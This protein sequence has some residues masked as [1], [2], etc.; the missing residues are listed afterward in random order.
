M[1]QKQATSLYSQI[2]N[3]LIPKDYDFFKTLCYTSLERE[4]LSSILSSNENLLT[5]GSQFSHSMVQIFASGVRVLE[6]LIRN[7][8]TSG[9]GLHKLRSLAENNVDNAGIIHNTTSRDPSTSNA[10]MQTYQSSDLE[11]ANDLTELASESGRRSSS[12]SVNLHSMLR[13]SS[14]DAISENRAHEY[15]GG[16]AL[17][18]ALE[19]MRIWFMSI[20]KMNERSL[21]KKNTFGEHSNNDL[22]P[23]LFEVS[24]QS[25][26]LNEKYFFDFLAALKLFLKTSLVSI[27]DSK[28]NFTSNLKA[29]KAIIFLLVD[30]LSSLFSSFLFQEIDAVPVATKA[31]LFLFFLVDFSDIFDSLLRVTSPTFDQNA[32]VYKSPKVNLSFDTLMKVYRIIGILS[33]TSSKILPIVPSTLSSDITSISE[34]LNAYDQYFSRI[35][36]IDRYTFDLEISLK[37]LPI[38]AIDFKYCYLFKPDLLEHRI[39]SASFANW[40]T[41][42]LFNGSNYMRYQTINRIVDFHKNYKAFTYSKDTDDPY[43][44]ELEK[45]QLSRMTSVAQRL[46]DDNIETSDMLPIAFILFTYSRSLS[47]LQALISEQLLNLLKL[48]NSTP[49]KLL[50][51]WLSTLSYIFQYQYRTVNLQ[52]V[53]KLLLAILVKLT[54]NKSITKDS[55]YVPIKALKKCQIDENIWKLSHQ[56]SPI[57]PLSPSG[58]RK[59]HLFYILDTLQNLIRFNLTKRLEIDNY[60]LCFSIIFQILKE[61]L[62]DKEFD[63][64]NYAWSEFSKSVVMVLVFVKKQNILNSKYLKATNNYA[65]LM[66]LIEEILI[67]INILLMKRFCSVESKEEGST[68]QKSIIYDLIYNILLNYDL[69]DN[70]LIE[71]DLEDLPNL[72]RLNECITY[73]DSQF[74]FES[75][76]AHGTKSKRDLQDVE[77]DSPV[78]INTISNFTAEPNNQLFNELKHKYKFKN[79]FRYLDMN[80]DEAFFDDSYL[81]KIFYIMSKDTL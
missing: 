74:H 21:K 4:S 51:I 26:G 45:I 70:I 10:D 65:S 73:L 19:V 55:K 14:L 5:S 36:K 32:V 81:V 39:R 9:S 79:T 63:I 30:V 75:S 56:K 59:S 60:N 11:E 54:S 38:L 1:N 3:P 44:A 37:M 24:K 58:G 67:V 66:A 8:E 34:S 2:F 25:P 16:Q 68:D 47:F 40:L 77:Y 7:E 41:A 22:I 76:L 72:K 43:L 28:P 61:F 31:L 29:M 53:A 48:P 64:S 71:Y 49:I 17:L 12:I 20:S 50:E 15:E 6:D 80:Y 27:Q 33:N 62:E 18:N 13:L 42:N 23:I 69:F 57:I 78:L 46:E 35:K 52:A